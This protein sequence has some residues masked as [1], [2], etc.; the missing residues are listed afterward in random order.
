MHVPPCDSPTMPEPVGVD[1]RMLGE[2]VETAREIPQVQ[3]E[4]VEA[5]H[6]RVHL[7]V[8]AVVDVRRVPV[9]ALAEAAQVRREHDVPAQRELV[10]VVRVLRRLAH[11]R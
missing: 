6:R 4:H 9:G 3:R 5:E 8:V 11:A 1:E 2:H 10:P 7:R